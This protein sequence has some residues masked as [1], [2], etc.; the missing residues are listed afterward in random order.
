MSRE[1]E[2]KAMQELIDIKMTQR[3]GEK[4]LKPTIF[5]KHAEEEKKQQQASDNPGTDQQVPTTG[6]TQDSDILSQKSLNI[7]NQ[8][9][10]SSDEYSCFG[11]LVWNFM[12]N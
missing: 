6:Q 3:V 4:P 7:E 5:A 1:D 10:K 2:R 9:A 8:S 11:D 12:G